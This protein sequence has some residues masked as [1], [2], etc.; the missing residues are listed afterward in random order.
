LVQ[1]CADARLRA[2]GDGARGVKD[3]LTFLR[4]GGQTPSG[5]DIRL[6]GKDNEGARGFPLLQFLEKTRLDFCRDDARQQGAGRVLG[7]AGIKARRSQCAREKDG[8]G[9]EGKGE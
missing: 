9:E 5:G 3:V 6:L 4:F 7:R 1:E 8:E 2:A